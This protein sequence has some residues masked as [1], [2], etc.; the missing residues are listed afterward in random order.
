[1]LDILLLNVHR[2]YLNHHPQY[3]G[4][5]GIYLLAAFLRQEG[6]QAKS[7]SATLVESQKIVDDLCGACTV[8][9]VGLYCDYDNVTENIYLCHY[10]KYRYGLPVVVG[11]PQATAL[12]E[13]FYIESTCDAIVRYEGELTL[14]ELMN[15]YLEGIGNLSTICGISYM[16]SGCLKTNE[17]RPLIENLDGLPFIDEEC[18]L[19]PKYYYKGLSIMTGRGCPFH[20]AFCHEGSHTRKVRFRSVD[21]V[22]AEIDLYLSKNT[23][24]NIYILFTDDTLT[25][26]PK[27]VKELCNGISERQAKKNFRWFCEGHIHSLYTHPEMITDLARAGCT[28]IQLGIE[29]GTAAVLKAYGK[30]TTPEEI[31]SVV[32]Q[33]RDAGISQIYGNIIL[34]G[35]YFSKEIYNLDQKFVQKLLKTSQGTLEMGTVTFWPL[36]ETPMTSNPVNYGIKIHDRDFITSVG[37]FPQASTDELTRYEIA[38][39]QKQFE[40][41]ITKQMI[42]MLENWE[43]PTERILSWFKNKPV[44]DGAGAWFL[45]LATHEVLYSYY[46]MLY[47]GE[48]RTSKDIIDISKAHPLRV[49]PLYRYLSKQGDS[50]FDVRGE[51]FSNDEMKVVILTTGKVSVK[52]IT[53]HTGLEMDTVLNVLN[54][55]EKRHLIVYTIL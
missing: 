14:L 38:I 44:Q 8:S 45:K 47:L 50:H 34:A 32:Q 48:G 52:D 3:G 41:N 30:N 19:D 21:N 23:A 31:F 46:E 49:V 7:H 15:Y 28:R 24:D 51:K 26:Q 22:L 43:V 40:E 37:D 17:D 53:N 6:Y 11:G 27:R 13:D 1:M 54:R 4:F 9:M 29:A 33:C 39:M 55:L 36:S 2:R 42:D 16:E 12:K 35:A 20:C 5:L 25:L 18:Y 10:I